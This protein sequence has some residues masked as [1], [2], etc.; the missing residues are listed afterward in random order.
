MSREQKL[1]NICFELVMTAK[2]WKDF[3][4]KSYEEIAEYVAKNLRGCGF[5][6]EPCGSSW[7]VLIDEKEKYMKDP[8]SNWNSPDWFEATG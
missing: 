4:S 5:D 3:Q 7:G 8:L 6:T 1:I 2:D